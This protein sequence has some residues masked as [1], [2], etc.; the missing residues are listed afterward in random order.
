MRLATIPYGDSSSVIAIFADNSYGIV[1]DLPGRR[2]SHDVSSLITSPLLDEEVDSLKQNSLDLDP[3]QEFL[4]PLV[5]PKNVL[6]VGKNYVAH[7]IEGALAEGLASAEIPTEPIWFTKAHTCLTGHGGSIKASGAFADS[8]DYE[9][10]LAVIIGR[11]SFG[12]TSENALG[13][14]FGY[15]IFNDITARNLQRARKQWFKGKSADTFGPIGPWIVTSNEIE[16]PQNLMI[17]TRVN[18]EIRQ[19]DSTKNMIFSV[20]DLLVDISSG[21]TLE[22]GDVIA[23]G[24]PEGVAWGKAGK[25]LLP[26][27]LVSVEIEKIGRLDNTVAD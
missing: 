15:T 1:K 22:P 21:L 5:P 2:D 3:G 18:G 24:T 14:V 4:P 16:D 9:G 6:C 7:A 19:H 20:I 27:D 11:K 10:E 17:T 23:T 12:L 13:S 26:G 25:Y 8:L